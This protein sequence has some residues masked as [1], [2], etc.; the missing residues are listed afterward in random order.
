MRLPTRGRRSIR[1]TGYDATDGYATD[2]RQSLPVRRRS[3]AGEPRLHRARESL[4]E[5]THRP[6][7]FPVG[8]V[9]LQELLTVHGLSVLVLHLGDDLLGLH[10]DH[11]RRRKE[12]VLPVYAHGDPVG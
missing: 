10:V 1:P 2:A 8:E 7:K 3:A 9:H 12:G 11:V 5:L 6:L 4:S